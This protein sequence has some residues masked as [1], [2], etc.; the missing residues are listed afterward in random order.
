MKKATLIKL[1]K[2]TEAEKNTTINWLNK[3]GS[4]AKATDGT[5]Y[6]W[7]KIPPEFTSDEFINMYYTK[8]RLHS[9]PE[10]FLAQTARA[11]SE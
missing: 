10:R 6:L 11:M 9:P 8:H 7:T 3:L 5:Y 2:Y 4:D 1:I